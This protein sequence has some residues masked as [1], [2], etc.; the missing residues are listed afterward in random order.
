MGIAQGGVNQKKA[1][2]CPSM[3]LQDSEEATSSLR[4]SAAQLAPGRPR[5]ANRVKRQLLPKDLHR[6]VQIHTRSYKS[7]LPPHTHLF[8]TPRLAGEE[9]QVIQVASEASRSRHFSLNQEPPP[10]PPSP[11]KMYS[12]SAASDQAPVQDRPVGREPLGVICCQELPCVAPK[13]KRSS[14]A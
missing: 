8:V 12:P 14:R 11:P 9:P 1:V 7:R 5:W 6:S 10:L 4:V 3:R 2:A 13:S